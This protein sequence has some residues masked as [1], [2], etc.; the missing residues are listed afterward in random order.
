MP[1][2][3]VDV[4]AAAIWWASL[5]NQVPAEAKGLWFGLFEAAKDGEAV[6]TLYVAGTP[7]F[8]ADDETA[9]W[10]CEYVWEAEGRYVVLPG[11]AALPAAPYEVPLTHAAEVVRQLRPWRGRDAVG[12]AVGYDD[13]DFVILHSAG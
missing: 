2:L 9:E 4:A 1:G 5:R 13:G 10:A 3:E 6:R 12:V 8:D 7:S 11:L